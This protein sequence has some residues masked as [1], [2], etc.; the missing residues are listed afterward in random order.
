MTIQN[1]LI[2]ESNVVANIV[3][4]DGDTTVWT[5]PS[6]SIVLVQST[7]PAFI[8]QSNADET[9]CVIVEE[10]GAGDIGFI[11]NGSVLMTNQPKPPVQNVARTAPAIQTT[12]VKPTEPTPQTTFVN[13]LATATQTAYIDVLDKGI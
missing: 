9:D 6:G 10:L 5:P 4:W 1:Y 11:W 7:T 13:P 3:V 8:W 2:I 12:F